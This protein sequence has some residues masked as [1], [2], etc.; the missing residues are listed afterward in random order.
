VVASTFSAVQKA[1]FKSV[2][3]PG[4]SSVMPYQILSRY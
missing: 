1:G 3:I 4:Q 2:R